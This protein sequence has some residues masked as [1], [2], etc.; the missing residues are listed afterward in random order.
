VA[1]SGSPRGRRVVKVRQSRRGRVALFEG[2][3]G[4]VLVRARGGT[5]RVK[6]HRFD[7]DQVGEMQLAADAAALVQEVYRHIAD[8]P[9]ATMEMVGSLRHIEDHR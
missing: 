2:P 9:K 7:G 5:V 4:Y 3:A 6:A 1:A 8:D